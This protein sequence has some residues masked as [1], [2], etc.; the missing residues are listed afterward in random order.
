MQLYNTFS[1]NEL[2]NLIQAGDQAA[3]GALYRR[4]WQSMFNNAYKRLKNRDISQDV[5][6]NVFTDIWDRREAVV[7]EN[8]P[9]YLHTAVRFQVI[10][11]SVAAP[12]HAAMID[13][14]ETDIVSA[15]R[16]D[17]TLIGNEVKQLLRLWIDALPE[18]RREIFI[19]HYFNG[20]STEEIAG[21]LQISQKT[22]QNQLHTA[23]TAI[24]SHFD[25]IL[26]AEV[27]SSFLGI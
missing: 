4:H 27:I 25:K 2:F 11:Q 8:I 5:V 19:L 7:I 24:K 26:L 17:D 20:K 3:F 9:A 16:A 6:Q 23:T 22:V 18:K 1:D 10:K 13:L 12:D 15:G 14:F 21:H